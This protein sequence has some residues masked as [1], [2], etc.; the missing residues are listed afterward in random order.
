MQKSLRRPLFTILCLLILSLPAIQATEISDANCS[1]FDQPKSLSVGDLALTSSEIISAS[2]FPSTSFCGT[3]SDQGCASA[4]EWTWC[5]VPETGEV[6][7][8]VKDGL[9]CGPTRSHCGCYPQP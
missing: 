5:F 6:G 4:P 7:Q 9:L 1:P 2:S 3:C 8:C